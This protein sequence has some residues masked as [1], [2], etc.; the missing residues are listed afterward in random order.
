MVDRRDFLKFAAAGPAALGA[1]TSRGPIRAAVFGLEHSHTTGK[2]KAMKDSPDYQVAAVWDP[3][4]A[5]RARAQKEPLFQ[6]V[7]FVDDA[8]MLADGSIELVVVECH[9]WEALDRGER[10]IAA[11]KHLHLE[12]PPGNDWG[13]FQA[14]VAEARRKKLLLQTGYVWRWH[15]GVNAAIE[16]A[17]KGWLGRVHMVRG[18]MSADRDAAQRAVEARY[19]GGGFFELA[20][21]AIDPTVRLLGRPS[22]VQGWFRHHTG[23][24]DRLA[25]NSVAVFEFEQA[26]AVI[27]QSA[28]MAGAT[29]YRCFEV[30]GTDGSFL[31]HPESN[32]PRMRV[33]LREARGSYKA[34]W[35]DVALPPQPRFAGDFRELARAIRSGTALE[36]SYEHELLLQETLLRAAGEIAG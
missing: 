31:V 17:R 14:L 15:E 13:R 25:D 8:A 21:H 2:F 5:V 26:L 11:G 35:Q 22:K 7:P 18:N 27:T 19:K 20:G 29:D 3:D 12:K 36:L 16:A 9:V 30:I 34:G 28:R 24:D 23:V 10:V 32:P 1:Q 33:Y 4:P 6:G